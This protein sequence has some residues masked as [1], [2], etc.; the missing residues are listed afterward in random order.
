MGSAPNCDPLRHG[1]IYCILGCLFYSPI[2]YFTYW[3]TWSIQDAYT[4]LE[5]GHHIINASWIAVQVRRFLGPL[6]LRKYAPRLP[7]MPRTCAT[8]FL[9]IILHV[10]A[11]YCS[12]TL[13]PPYHTVNACYYT[14]L[15]CVHTCACLTFQVCAP[16][17]FE[18]CREPLPSPARQVSTLG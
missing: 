18:E 15:G 9:L 14:K 2:S 8:R 7:A 3:V 11:C 5:T 16:V 6:V 13:L 12:R 1:R 4:T 10:H 17:Q